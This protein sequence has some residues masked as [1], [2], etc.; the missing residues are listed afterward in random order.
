MKNG[1]YILI[2]FGISMLLGAC[3]KH[4][5]FFSLKT[6]LFYNCSGSPAANAR[7]TIYRY[8]WNNFPPEKEVLSTG[9]TDSSGHILL[10][11]IPLNHY[12]NFKLEV[13]NK[14]WTD[15]T[16]SRKPLDGETIDLGRLY[17]SPEM[18]TNI[19][20]QTSGNWGIRDTL[21]LGHTS[22]YPIIIYPVT[23]SIIHH[24][25]T[26][27]R[28]FP[29]L[30]YQSGVVTMY[31]GI[32]NADFLKMFEKEKPYN[33]EGRKVEVYTRSCQI[34]PVPTLIQINK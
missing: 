33:F 21:Y 6:Q 22:Y 23:D 12:K 34:P 32:G 30:P 4:K 1:I 17:Q 7:V 29:E 15:K 13:G 11:N 31:W 27:Y 10:E 18:H 3:D 25:F 24:I 20:L 16:L 5:K 26:D 9:F 28:Q 19:Q 14:E 8:K 2:L